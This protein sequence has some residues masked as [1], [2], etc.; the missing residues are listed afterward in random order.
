MAFNT[1][2]Q[3]TLSRLTKAFNKFQ[4]T[5]VNSL[6][7]SHLKNHLL[8]M[9]YFFENPQKPHIVF[10]TLLYKLFWLRKYK[11]NHYKSKVLKQYP[12]CDI[13]SYL[14]LNDSWLFKYL[15][16]FKYF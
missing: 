14:L 10:C 11:Q 9:S 7:Y 13:T 16:I 5:A 1:E 3:Q 4:E 12:A 15:H 6:L 2:L 8:T